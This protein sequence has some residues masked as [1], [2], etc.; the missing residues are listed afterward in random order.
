L[1]EEYKPSGPYK[2]PI[3]RWMSLEKMMLTNYPRLQ[4]DFEKLRRKVSANGKDGKTEE[5]K[6]HLEWLLRKGENKKA[7]ITCPYCKKDPVKYFFV[8]YF[9]Y[10]KKFV[11]KESFAFC[12]KKSCQSDASPGAGSDGA[13]EVLP[14]KFSSIDRFTLKKDQK[15]ITRLLKKL[16]GLNSLKN[17][18]LFRFFSC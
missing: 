12:G 11:V 10:E 6:K 18:D 7:Q 9:F 3:R 1:P 17:E 8:K 13:V 2:F 14:V 4:K 5:K 15:K 16:F